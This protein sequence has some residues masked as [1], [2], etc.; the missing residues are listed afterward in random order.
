MDN[1]DAKALVRNHLAPTIVAATLGLALV[2]TA[3]PR[4]ISAMLSLD[5]RNV[6]SNLYQ[7]KPVREG[8]L[9]AAAVDLSMAHDWYPEGEVETG[10]GYLLLQQAMGADNAEKRLSL[11]REAAAATLAGLEEAPAQP[12]A[13]ARL[14]WLRYKVGDSAEAAK[15]YRMSLLTGAVVPP[16]MVSRLELG[17]ALRSAL[18]ADTQDML[19][20]QV[21]LTWVLDVDAITRLA[22][23]P[24][25]GAF[26]RSSLANL[27]Q[28]QM[29]AFSLR[30]A[31]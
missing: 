24:A 13:W 4:L 20:R 5:A 23:N 14:A 7:G 26:V 15:A 30:H 28:A 8:Q 21:C 18:D 6:L 22:A 2:V 16:L 31:R 9:A 19:A 25:Y 3:T 29:D 12:V 10:R 11:L 1:R 27:T 17:F